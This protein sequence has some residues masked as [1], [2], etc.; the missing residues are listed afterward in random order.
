M[1]GW[2]GGGIVSP[3][4]WLRRPIFRGRTR[5]AVDLESL[6]FSLYKCTRFDIL[7]ALYTCTTVASRVAANAC[8]TH[9][10][11]LTELVHSLAL[12]F[13]PFDT[14]LSPTVNPFRRIPPFCPKQP[15][16]HKLL[17]SISRGSPI[18][19]WY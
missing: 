13:K 17:S 16:P 1:G 9:L 6:C 12:H 11:F 7:A 19:F 15:K 3:A 10:R 4:K 8:A 14:V 18:P 2:V 5:H